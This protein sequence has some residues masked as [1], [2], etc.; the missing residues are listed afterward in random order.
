MKIATLRRVMTFH[1]AI[2]MAFPWMVLQRFAVRSDRCGSCEF[3]RISLILDMNGARRI[4][5]GF[6]KGGLP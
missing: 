4:L 1:L 2:H 3:M 5:E 6:G